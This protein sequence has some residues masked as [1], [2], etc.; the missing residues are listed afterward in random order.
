VKFSAALVAA[1]ALI[2]APSIYAAVI[3]ADDF[4]Y[5]DGH[6]GTQNGGTGWQI[7]WYTASNPNGGWEVVAGRAVSAFVPFSSYCDRWYIN[8]AATP[9]LFISLDISVDQF[10][11]DDVIGLDLYSG[12]NFT[13]LAFGK[14]QGHTDFTLNFSPP[15]PTG[16]NIVPGVTY[17]V[18]GMYDIANARIAL[19][20]NPDAADFYNPATG[21]NSADAA[22]GYNPAHVTGLDLFTYRPGVGQLA[23]VHFDNLI[24]ADTPE[25]V[26]LQSAATACNCRGDMN[27]DGVRDGRD[28]A[29]FVNCFISGG[30]CA[31][32]DMDGMNGVDLADMPAFVTTLLTA[33]DCP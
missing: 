22:T 29:H 7:P 25:S 17:H 16:I 8:P 11:I 30:D 18:I 24:I 23:G 4:S 31:C 13:A 12:V 6:L 1:A 33:H 5:P 27:R 19:W 3:A 15:I 21:Q 20:V 10:Q 9:Q 32:A 2:A 26:G 14:A 28:I